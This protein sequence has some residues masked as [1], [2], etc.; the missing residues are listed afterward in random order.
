[1][2]PVH[3]SIPIGLGSIL[4]LLVSIGTLALP[5]VTQIVGIFENV[6]VHWT[7]GEKISLIA[8]AVTT[9]V[10]V[11]ARAAQAVAAILKEKN[12]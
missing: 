9:A 7:E 10:T 2:K 6:A 11:L 12:L 8:G 4:G 3:G 1:M 5:V